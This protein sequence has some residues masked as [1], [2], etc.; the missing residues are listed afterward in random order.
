MSRGALGPSGLA[1]DLKRDTL[2]IVDGTNDTLVAFS[3]VSTIPAGGIT[4]EKA[5]RRFPGLWRAGAIGVSGAPLNASI[6]SALLFNGN[7]VIGNTGNPSGTNL[8]VEISRAGKLLDT[9]NVDKGASGSIFGMVATGKSA[10]TTKFYF[11]DDNDNN[12]Q[13]LQK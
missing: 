13:V 8:M 9:L 5:E 1:Y 12:L 6:S 4:V 2:Y 7:L 3:K 10:A 11:N